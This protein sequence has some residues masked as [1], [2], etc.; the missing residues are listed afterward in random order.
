MRKPIG[1]IDKLRIFFYWM[2]QHKGCGL[3]ATC[4]VCESTR[5]RRLEWNSDMKADK[6]YYD[7]RY[8]CLDCKA[9]GQNLEEWQ[10]V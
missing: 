8:E 6:A 4:S 9:I 5:I 2:S 7:G 3:I 10:T 1:F